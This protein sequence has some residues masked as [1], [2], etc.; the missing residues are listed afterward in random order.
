MLST[1]ILERESWRV[2]EDDSNE[3]KPETEMRSCVYKVRE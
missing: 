1:D 3:E 2:M